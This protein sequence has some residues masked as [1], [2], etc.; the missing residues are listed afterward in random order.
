MAYNDDRYPKFRERWET[1][2]SQ[3]DEHIEG[4][5]NR[6]RA[7][8][9]EAGSTSE[10][11]A[12]AWDET[13]R[14][15]DRVGDTLAGRN[16][17]DTLAERTGDKVSSWWAGLKNNVSDWFN[18]EDDDTKAEAKRAMDDDEYMEQRFN[19]RRDNLR[20]KGRLS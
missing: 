16:D 5:W 1:R 18:D 3:L 13:K 15:G 11:A 2:G 19:E 6:T 8:T 7:K 12:G 4:W 17:P 10:A 9:R 14:T 20:D